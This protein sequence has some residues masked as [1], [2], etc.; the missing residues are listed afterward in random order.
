M[1]V[2]PASVEK[3]H[4]PPV[5]SSRKMEFVTQQLPCVSSSSLSFSAPLHDCTSAPA[6]PPSFQTTFPSDYEILTPTDSA[7]LLQ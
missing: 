3:Q 6:H 2:K 1:Y 7:T 4:N 5:L